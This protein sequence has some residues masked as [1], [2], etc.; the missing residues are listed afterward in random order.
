MHQLSKAERQAGVAIDLA[1]L[2]AFTQEH[3]RPI[4]ERFLENWE[5]E[6]DWGGLLEGAFNRLAILVSL[7]QLAESVPAVSQIGDAIDS[8]AEAELGSLLL[9]LVVPR[10]SSSVYP[11]AIRRR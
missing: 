9:E 3:M 11:G 6:T 2:E 8:S 1:S 7:A 10:G 5:G 4:V